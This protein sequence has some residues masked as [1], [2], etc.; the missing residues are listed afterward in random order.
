[1]TK[2][3]KVNRYYTP[4]YYEFIPGFRYQH[5]QKDEVN[6][7]IHIVTDEDFKVEN[8]QSN[9]Q[10]I[11]HNLSIPYD[12]KKDFYR[13]KL[14]DISDVEEYGFTKTTPVYLNNQGYDS[15]TLK[16]NYTMT[17]YA[18]SGKSSVTISDKYGNSLFEGT[19]MNYNELGNILE[20]LDI[21]HSLRFTK[22]LS[23]INYETD[24]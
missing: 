7:N 1:M 22:Q 6:W 17:L 5:K 12:E 20:R 9:L 14:L 16:G 23:D 11:M 2:L 4:V 18:T 19:V 13:V 3:K 24:E 8:C 15:F 10:W 21:M